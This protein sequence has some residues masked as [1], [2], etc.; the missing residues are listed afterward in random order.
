MDCVFKETCN[1][2]H[3]A[4]DEISLSKVAGRRGWWAVGGCWQASALNMA[5]TLKFKY[6]Y[7]TDCV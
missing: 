5:G 4:V 2:F 7:C 6:M 1:S 3:F